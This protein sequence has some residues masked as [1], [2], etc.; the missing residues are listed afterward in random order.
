LADGFNSGDLRVYIAAHKPAGSS[1]DVYYK[2]LAGGDRELWQDKKWQLMTQI[3]NANYYSETWDD[4]AELTFAPGTNGV[5]NN[6]ISYNSGLSGQFN[7]FNSFAIK[8]VLS[9]SNTV[10]VPRI[11]DFRAIAVPASFS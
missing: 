8:I 9:G 2:I 1:I 6:A 4:Y 10:D 5:P 7:D 3:D 11:R